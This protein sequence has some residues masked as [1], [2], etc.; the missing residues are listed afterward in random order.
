MEKKAI[1]I[2]GGSFNPPHNSHFALA[3]EILN[4]IENVEKV[5]FLPVSSKYAKTNLLTNEHRFQ[6]LKLVCDKIEKFEVSDIELIQEKQLNTTLELLQEKYPDHELY[7]VIGTDNLRELYWWGYIDLLLAKYKIIV[8]E[9]GID[10]IDK[11]IS[12]QD[13]LQ[14]YQKSFIRYPQ[15]IVT[16]L[17]STYI[18]ESLKKNHDINF[19]LPKEVYQYIKENNLYRG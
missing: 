11:I 4:E 2:F 8:L 13:F 12:S 15:K 9:R 10:N 5:V 6:M 3:E 19:L 7:F 18:R 17:S 14:K 16:N 1:A